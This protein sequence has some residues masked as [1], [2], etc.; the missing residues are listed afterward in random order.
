[1]NPDAPVSRTFMSPPALSRTFP[2]SGG[3]EHLEPQLLDHATLQKGL[4]HRI[5]HCNERFDRFQ[6]VPEDLGVGGSLRVERGNPLA[7]AFEHRIPLAPLADLH[8]VADGFLE[9]CLRAVRRLTLAGL[10][11]LVDE[12]PSA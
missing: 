11:M 3:D 5:D 6:A 7:Q 8:D 9:V 10:A 1:M 2:G 4:S 12:T